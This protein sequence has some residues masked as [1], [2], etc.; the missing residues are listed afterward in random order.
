MDSPKKGTAF[1]DKAALC[2]EIAKSIKKQTGNELDND[3]DRQQQEEKVKRPK[4]A[5]PL[6]DESHL[7][8]QYR[9]HE[10]ISSDELPEDDDFESTAPKSPTSK[11]TDRMC[12]VY[13]YIYI[14]P[15]SSALKVE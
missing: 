12:G 6:Q 13:S 10:N 7:P 8:K 5:A 4:Y 1:L 2:G 14:I 3:S 11:F 15:F 9:M